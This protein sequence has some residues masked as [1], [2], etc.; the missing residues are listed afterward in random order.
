[1]TA[2][3]QRRA[4]GT[5][6]QRS[7]QLLLAGVEAP[8]STVDAL[9]FA[10]QP[11]PAALAQVVAVA[12]R[13]R[14]RARPRL[15]LIAP[16]RL[17]VSLHGLGRYASV[18]ED[19]V[20]RACAV[21]ARISATPFTLALDRVETFGRGDGSRPLVLT[22]SDGAVRLHELRHRLGLEIAAAGLPHSAERAYVPHLTLAYVREVV[23]T[24]AIEPVAWTVDELVLIRSVQGRGR[25]IVA[26]RW[27]L[28]EG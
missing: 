20:R 25:H 19:I 16:P 15:H 11:A 1:M 22:V 2:T 28:A 5:A 8:P 21:A 26:G 17:H 24:M 14:K 4:I 27:Y 7:T 18:P 12:A 9:F 6:Q 3:W 13:L 10:L 23:P